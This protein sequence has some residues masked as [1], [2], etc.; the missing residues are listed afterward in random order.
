MSTLPTRPTIFNV[1]ISAVDSAVE[2]TV[3]SNAVWIALKARD[4]VIWS[5]EGSVGSPITSPY[6][7]L[8]AGE[9]FSLP[10]I[11]NIHVPMTSR[12]YFAVPSGGTVPAVVEIALA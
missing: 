12:L 8:D 3:P 2:F 10:D 5:T 1:V 6:S 4:D 11:L 9:G 7:E